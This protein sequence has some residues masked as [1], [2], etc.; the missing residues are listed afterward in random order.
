MTARQLIE[1]ASAFARREMLAEAQQ[2]LQEARAAL[3][4]R[5]DVGPAHWCDACLVALEIAARDGDVPEME[6]EAVQLRSLSRGGRYWTE[7]ARARI[8]GCAGRIAPAHLDRVFAI[9]AGE[10]TPAAPHRAPPSIAERAYEG[11]APSKIRARE[12]LTDPLPAED[13]AAPDGNPVE[14]PDF[15][16]TARLSESANDLHAILFEDRRHAAGSVDAPVASCNTPLLVAAAVEPAGL[17]LPAP[18]PR[19]HTDRYGMATLALGP[20]PQSGLHAASRYR[21]VPRRRMGPTAGGFLVVLGLAAVICIYFFGADLRVSSA[22]PGSAAEQASQRGSATHVLGFANMRGN[23]PESVPRNHLI[24]GQALLSSGDTAGA[25]AA[26]SAAA[27][28]DSR[29]TVAWTA[30]ETLARL[31]GHSAA[32]AD[33]YL[34]AYAAG[35][36]ADRAQAVAHAQ[37]LAGRPERAERVRQQA[38]AHSTPESSIRH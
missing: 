21:L 3:A 17:P 8:G 18:L 19:R 30:A 27:Q 22:R 2:A 1:S 11:A 33:A 13:H 23:N 31:P 37:E 24:R 32:A 7:Q 5:S 20:A 35:L 10:A 38:A 14:A 6:A 25:I 34:L 28:S 15:D 12:P 4:L 29:G 36:P 16:W 9:L 26:L